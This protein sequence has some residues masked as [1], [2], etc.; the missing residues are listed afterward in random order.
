MRRMPASLTRAALLFACAAA[1]GAMAQPGPAPSA[2][3]P[4]PPPSASPPSAPPTSPA[5]APPA[6]QVEITGT[7]ETD[8]EARRQSTASK[9]VIGREE[10]DKFGDA[11]LGEVLRRLPGV[12]TPGAPG[13]G[14][15]PRLRG[16]G[17]GYTQLLIDGQRVPP[18]FALESLTPEQVERIEIL[19]APTAETGARAIAGTINIVTREG[20]RRRLNEVR[21]G[22]GV[23]NGEP[24]TG[25][26]W[27]HND[28]AG[29]LSYTLSTGLFRRFDGD[30]NR[31]RTTVE[32]AATGTLLEDES[33]SSE[34]RNARTGLNV[35]G[36]LNW[37]LGA[38]GD[39]LLIAPSLFTSRSD[40]TRDFRLEQ[41]LPVPSAAAPADYAFG[42]TE[43]TNR[44]TT[45]RV[46]GQWRQRLGEAGPR[47][48]LQGNVG[49]F[50]ADN[51]SLRVERNEAGAPLRTLADTSRT[52]ERSLNLA[53]K[54]SQLV[55]GRERPAPAAPGAAG[56]A[57]AAPWV[58]DHSLVGGGEIEV[59]QRDETRINLQDGEPLLADFGEN[60]QART[61]RLALY[62]QDEWNPTPQ[63]S[64]YAGLRW[65][66]IRTEG[67]LGDGTRPV[68]TSRVWTPLA[69]AV[70]K[71]DPAARDQVRLSLTRSY[72]SPSTANLI[73]RP[74]LAAN[75]P[76]SGPNLP[77]APDRAGNP[78]LRPELATGLDVAVER[79]LKEGGV[80]SAS[81][82]V[83]RITDLIRGVVALEPVSWSA[84]PRYV[85]R[86]QN[87]GD[88]TTR[89]I[90][91]DAR[92]RLDQLIGGAP[93]VEVRANASV[94]DSDVQGV[95]GPDNR[96]AEQPKGTA[97]LGA[98]WRLR[99]TPF[100]IGGNLNWVPAYETQLSEERRSRTG[101]KRVFDAYAL[102]SFD[103]NTALRLLAS[104]LVPA[105]TIGGSTFT[106]GGTVTRTESTGPSAVNWQLRLELKL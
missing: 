30:E 98:D 19:R 88:A 26:F 105:D 20:F 90:E 94:F 62:A 34:N 49:G 65:E 59:V 66:A 91:L 77:T 103:P 75:H 24:S 47:M 11:T 72:R 23:E 93:P 46:N 58:V 1:A 28:S 87:I 73:A 63:W 85:E 44:F 14:G 32:D 79:Y 27:T 42:R 78:G 83:R 41:V 60:L 48:E 57:G 33:V 50:E 8:T 56:A 16:L 55:G 29:D 17:G 12:T 4:A 68:N 104:N 70:W 10:I 74:S 35:S 51:R 61:T 37:R 96:L 43:S 15:P 18:G 21:V 31:T 25:L 3:A 45:M 9:I 54:L 97:N 101:T 39:S 92:F 7:R 52:S 76:V 5:P 53:L 13:R 81:V 102:W 106:S 36:R 84:V 99:G 67:D 22:A 40:S 100:T 71:P 95:P 82:F 80:L 69:H 64:A 6:Q 86:P 38:P 2:P 89:G